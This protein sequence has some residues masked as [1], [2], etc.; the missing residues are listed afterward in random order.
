MTD[1]HTAIRSIQAFG[2]GDW[3]GVELSTFADNAH[4]AAAGLRK[5]FSSSTSKADA[6]AQK[7]IPAITQKDIDRCREKFA[8]KRVSI[9]VI[10][11]KCVLVI[12]IPWAILDIY[13]NRQLN[14]A[15]QDLNEV[16][17]LCKDS[18]K[19]SGQ[20]HKNDSKKHT[21][22]TRPSFDELGNFAE[23]FRF[24]DSA[25]TTRKAH[26]VDLARIDPK[27]YGSDIDIQRLIRQSLFA[28]K[29][30]TL[31]QVVA[32][33]SKLMEKYEELGNKFGE[34]QVLLISASDGQSTISSPQRNT[35]RIIELRAQ[36]EVLISQA[37]GIE[38]SL[39]K[40]DE[41]HQSYL[42]D[43]TAPNRTLS[44][45]AHAILNSLREQLAQLTPALRAQAAAAARAKACS[46]LKLQH[47]GYSNGGNSCY[48]A[49]ALQ[50]IRLTPSYRQLFT[51][52][53]P[54]QELYQGPPAVLRE[55]ND[56]DHAKRVQLQALISASFAKLEAGI[57]V[58]TSEMN[59]IREQ[60]ISL[61]SLAPRDR[62]AQLDADEYLRIL[63]DCMVAST[64]VDEITGECAAS[65]FISSIHQ[66]I[67]SKGNE[68]AC[69]ISTEEVDWTKGTIDPHTSLDLKID[70]DARGIATSGQSIQSTLER[71]L[72]KTEP[73]DDYRVNAESFR[74]CTQ[75]STIPETSTRTSALGHIVVEGKVMGPYHQD[76]TLHT[77][78]P[79]LTLTLKRYSYDRQNRSRRISG[80]I[81]LNETIDVKNVL[82]TSISE[83][84]REKGTR[85]R[86]KNII[87]HSGASPNSGHYYMYT[88][89]GDS[90]QFIC[91]NDS[92]VSTKPLKLKEVEDAY[93]VTYER[94]EGGTED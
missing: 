15:I 45:E 88:R 75:S 69:E 17:N 49:S 47:A 1:A 66:R 80:A 85:Y 41:M 61:G 30:L 28:E 93:M 38:L 35:R 33:K 42:R 25:P 64:V 32:E 20:S 3:D 5:A 27:L 54:K 78:P 7:A 9:G 59:K 40:L 16:R 81:E 76:Y 43:Y 92:I 83:E 12:L 86:I 68:L 10:V 91:L 23:A 60:M 89:D 87:I 34:Y 31:E 2:R 84:E 22:T 65:P 39:K 11:L 29:P 24:S 19:E 90:D 50:T 79:T 51:R 73:G 63:L 82:H 44:N 52:P 53:V 55:I 57:T 94:I 4:T 13:N 67:Y 71:T 58:S 18:T 14:Q 6:I 56:Q 74:Q 72:G 62:Y 48:L 26:P 37:K 77:L 46:S 70:A 21:N 8:A 36:I